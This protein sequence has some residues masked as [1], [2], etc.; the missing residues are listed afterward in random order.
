[1]RPLTQMLKLV[2]LVVV[3][4]CVCVSQPTDAADESF[5]VIVNP[6]NP[7]TAVSRTFLRDAYL[8]RAADWGH[9][10]TVRPVDLSRPSSVRERFTHEVLRK[11][12]SQ[13]K[14]YWNQQIFSGKG[15]PPP[16]ATSP[17]GVIEYVMDHPGAIGY[18][19]SSVDPG[20]AKVILVR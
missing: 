7:I 10:T 1:M 13:L 17:M 4:T 16:A 19:P 9:G 2:V 8:K 3:C 6:E 5:K 11:S 14:N 12:P 18:L 15:V 20:S